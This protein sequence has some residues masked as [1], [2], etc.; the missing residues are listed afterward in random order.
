MKI[1]SSSLEMASGHIATQS[2]EV[3]ESLRM[4]S[5]SRPN[6]EGNASTRPAEPVRISD[7]GRSAQS[8]GAVASSEE[9][10][11]ND[12]R[13]RLLR[14]LIEFLTGKKAKLFDSSELN[15]GG[16]QQA[17]PAEQ[18]LP[19]AD[20]PENANFGLE[21][22][23]HSS[24]SETEQTAFAARGFVQTA[25]GKSIA[26]DLQFA[27]QRS[28]TEETNVSVRMGNAV[29]KKDPLVINFSGNA[30][31][32]TDTRF[33]FDLDADG[34]L[35]NINFVRQG[36]GFL[37]FD[38]NRDGKVNDGSELFGPATGNGFNEL[39]LLDADANGWIDE[40]DAAYENLL[41]W[42]KNAE[43]KDILMSL[44]DANV[45]AIALAN[46]ATPF[47]LKDDAN[48]TLGQVR[49]S[50]IYLKE[51]GNVGTIQQIDLTV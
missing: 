42:A 27:M 24:Y 21:Y 45:G 36:S 35:D 46:A 16:G 19:P 31:E 51:N 30:A 26:F 13:M 49:S 25:D 37:V 38:R 43:G 48:Q 9:A 50:G 44:K 10:V 39:A 2:L 1:A 33:K 18:A 4:W 29:R 17:V 7:A 28:Y 12:P 15:I 11:E 20:Q 5:G 3:R 14:A 41:V 23:Y 32:L 40:N 8:A 22:D 47:D 34:K 6:F